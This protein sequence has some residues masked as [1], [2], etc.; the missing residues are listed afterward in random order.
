MTSYSGNQKER[1][2]EWIK[3]CMGLRLTTEETL[4][5]LLENGFHISERTLRRYKQDIRKD[6]GE[7]FS[8][9]YYSEV[10]SYTVDDVFTFN[11]IQRSTS[12]LIQELPNGPVKIKAL[13]F[14]KDLILEKHKIY[15][16]IPLKFRLDDNDSEQTKMDDFKGI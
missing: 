12:N 8:K 15:G 6:S 4:E 7:T 5:K 14:L 3:V 9:M 2:L 1:L 10:I 13:S 11:E 16:N